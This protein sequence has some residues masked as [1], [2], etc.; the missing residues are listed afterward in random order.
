MDTRE[1]PFC[2]E[3]IKDTAVKCRYCHE[4]ITKEVVDYDLNLQPMPHFS[5]V[6]S[7]VAAVLSTMVP[8]LGQ[9]FRGKIAPGLAI[10]ALLA[11]FTYAG[12]YASFLWAFAVIIYIAN[13]YHAYAGWL[14]ESSILPE[15]VAANLRNGTD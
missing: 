11:V 6:F 5:P 12:L 13:I 10:M 1:C 2:A 9:I 15:G 7:G 4:F 14:F 8:G 3:T